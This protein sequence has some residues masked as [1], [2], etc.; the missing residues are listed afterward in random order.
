MDPA[1]SSLYKPLANSFETEGLYEEAFETAKK[2]SVSMNSTKS[3]IF[4]LQSS[5]KTKGIRKRRSCFVK[6]WRWI[7]DIWKP[8]IHCLP[9][10]LKKKTM[11]ASLNSFG[12]CA[13]TERMIRS[14]AGIWHRRSPGPKRT[15]KPAR[16][17]RTHFALSG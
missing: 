16:N 13:N 3:F 6:R 9:C 2:E 14:S 4:L 1:Y 10:F 5:L 17:M 12:K 15:T 7:P 8:F 11:R